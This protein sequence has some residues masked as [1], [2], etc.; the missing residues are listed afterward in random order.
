M[1]PATIAFLVNLAITAA[2]T[3]YSAHQSR[4]RERKARNDAAARNIDARTSGSGQDTPVLYGRVSTPLIEVHAA[5][6]DGIPAHATA[7][8]GMITGMRNVLGGRTCPSPLRATRSG[9]CT[10]AAR[11]TACRAA[12]TRS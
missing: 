10:P 6:G 2:T 4:K 12:R 7:Y 3:T 11:S 5:V 9:T 1:E 8:D